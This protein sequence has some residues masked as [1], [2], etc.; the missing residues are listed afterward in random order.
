ML[1]FLFQEK[2]N[3]G[4]TLMFMVAAK[5]CCKEARLSLGK[6]T[7]SWEGT[8]LGQLTETGQRG[9]LY[10]MISSGSF[11]GGGS[12]S[13]SLLLFVGLAGHQLEDGE[14]LLVH[15]LLYTFIYICIYTYIWS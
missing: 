9:I 13:C 11:G 2:N 10:H 3:V 4:N 12:S 14:Q 15:H 1:C 5:Q 7:R 8:E 6:E